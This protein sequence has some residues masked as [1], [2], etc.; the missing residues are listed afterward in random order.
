M[1]KISGKFFKAPDGAQYAK[2]RFCIS[3]PNGITKCEILFT[4]KKLTKKIIQ[5]NGEGMKLI[6]IMNIL[7]GFVAQN[8][9]RNPLWSWC[10]D[11]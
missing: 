7:S 5:L 3:Q 6:M 4:R 8:Q 2:T 10:K 9:R 1:H 11:S